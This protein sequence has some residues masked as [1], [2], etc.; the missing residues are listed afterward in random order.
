MRRPLLLVLHTVFSGLFLLLLAAVAPGGDCSAQTPG[1]IYLR[2]PSFED[3]PRNSRPP[4]GWT[5]CGFP[6]ETPP[7]VQPDPTLEFR[8]VKPAQHQQTY[9]GMVTRDNDTWERVGQQLAEPLVAGQCYEFRVQL[10]RSEFYVSRSRLT[11][12]QNN[13]VTPIKLRVR[14]GMAMCDMDAVLGESALVGNYDWQEYRMK[15]KPQ[16]DYT[17]I[18]LEAYYKTPI[19]FPY[20][21]NILVDNASPLVPIPCERNVSEDPVTDEVIA[22]AE[23]P[24]PEDEI[25]LTPVVP[26]TPQPRTPAPAPAPEPQKPKIKLGKTEAVLKEGQVFAIEDIT[27]KANSAELEDASEEALQEIVGF[28]QQNDGII[29]EIGGHASALASPTFANQISDARAK[30]V[31]AYLK[32]YDIGMER[33]F[34][35][36]YG[37]TR[38]VCNERDADCNRRNQRVEVKVLRIKES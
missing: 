12:Q 2:N 1:T 36:G 5:D 32:T 6:G 16:Q 29:V 30:S 23:Q 14:G 3:M 7:D 24:S 28:L 13:Y 20:N 26:R 27:F 31:V 8:V 34:P 11:Q 37:K 25:E 22:A 17:Y 33:I 9:I 10:A 4:T 18:A 35:R 21:G 19:L 15:L 38:P